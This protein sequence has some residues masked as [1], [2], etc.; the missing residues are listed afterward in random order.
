MDNS[1][2][3]THPSL[4]EL[5]DCLTVV[6]IKEVL[7]IRNSVRYGETIS[8]ITYDLDQIFS[9]I[10]IEIDVNFIRLIIAL[11]QINL[12]IWKNKDIMLDEPDRFNECM[13]LAHQLN[14]LRNQ[15]KN[16]ILVKTGLSDQPMAKSN[17][18]TD[19]L[20]GWS[21]S[22]LM[23]EDIKYDNEEIPNTRHYTFSLA[24]LID[25]LTINQIKEVFFQGEKQ[26]ICIQAIRQLS[27]DIDL[28]IKEKKIRLTGYL[29][30]LIVFISQA[31]L[32]TWYNKDRMQNDKDNYF[33][34]LK[35][36][37]E[38]NGLRNHVRNLLNIIFNELEPSN[39]KATFLDY[40]NKM[41]YSN[42]VEELNN[43]ECNLTTP[44]LSLNDFSSLFNTNIDDIPLDCRKIVKKEDFRYRKLDSTERDNVLLTI[45]KRINSGELWISGPDKKVIWENG[46]EENAKEYEET[47][48]LAVL[49]PKFLQSKKILRLNRDYVQ[50]FD[51][52]FEFNVIDV[53][54]RWIFQ[55]YFKNVEAIYEF[56][57]GSCQ[58]IPVLVELFPEKELHGL[59]WAIASTKI[60]ENLVSDKGWNVT[61]HIFDLYSPDDNVN[62]DETCGVFTIGTMEQ[63]GNNF[64][65]FLQFLLK[66]Q[67]AVIMH[68]EP[69]RELYNENYLADYLATQYDKKR[70]YLV[71]YLDRL[72]ELESEEK[73]QI[74]KAQRMLFGSMYHDSYSLIIWKFIKD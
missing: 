17:V 5:M 16:T 29:V 50:A 34:L 41:W 6:Q 48:D 13:K 39:Q 63:L 52:N 24:D 30:R 21:M 18:D 64:E 15:I 12:H 61:S 22:I 1:Y 9:E 23:S 42:I 71:G 69:I 72:R 4:A 56:G 38:M 53:Y 46:W 45:L 3:L 70:N 44:T 62:L 31:N 65:P 57:C 27:H 35:F 11:S 14:G 58:H 59:D 19:D 67:P 68:M 20:Q 47:R 28:L 49:M 43:S 25:S 60:I 33:D 40:S 73:I 32:H 74:I 7:D 54:R 66:K 8:R 51:P 2:L 55:K 36:A 10:E 37:Q 26:E